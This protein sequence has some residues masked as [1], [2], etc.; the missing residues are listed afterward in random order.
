MT[1]QE[2]E[3]QPIS[4]LRHFAFCR[5]QCALI[6]IERTW[7]ENRYTAEGRVMHERVHEKGTEKRKEVIISR[8]LHL[9]SLNYGI[10]GVSDVVEFH[11]ITEE[12]VQGGKGESVGAKL[13][14][15]Q[16]SW[17]P[18]PV[19][20]KRGQKKKDSCDEVQL[21]AQALC[22][23][24]MLQTQVPEGALFY[25]KNRRRHQVQFG[26][27]LREKTAQIVRDLHHLVASRNFVAQEKSAKCKYCSLRQVCLP[28]ISQRHQHVESYI[29]KNVNENLGEDLDTE[30]EGDR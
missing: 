30:R 29:R 23:E 13:P 8:G 2:D 9:R 16:G 6:H 11:Q 19:E 17:L 5:R 4:A 21:C 28:E 15:Q 22:L 25:G 24:E 14:G 12:L 3:L 20:Y 10:V 27:A 18:F 26:S 1:Y 7:V